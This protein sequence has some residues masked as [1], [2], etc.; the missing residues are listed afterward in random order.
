MGLFVTLRSTK[1]PHAP[2]QDP[3]GIMRC[4]GCAKFVRTASGQPYEDLFDNVM[5]NVPEHAHDTLACF[6]M[7]DIDHIVHVLRSS[8]PHGDELS[9]IVVGE[10]QERYLFHDNKYFTKEEN[11]RILTKN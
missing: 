10:D 4:P 2:R 5:P 3:R 1:A 8:I 6:C 7:E 11:E 9:I